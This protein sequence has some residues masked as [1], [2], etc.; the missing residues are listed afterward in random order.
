M[1]TILKFS[2]VPNH[3]VRDILQGAPDLNQPNFTIQILWRII[4]KKLRIYNKKLRIFYI[5]YTATLHFIMYVYIH[6]LS[7]LARKNL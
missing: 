5:I 6:W 4:K 7:I 3:V 1:I 2:L